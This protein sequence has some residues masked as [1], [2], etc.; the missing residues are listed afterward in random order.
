LILGKIF[1][2]VS[3]GCQ[4]LRLKC[5]KFNFGWDSVPDSAGEAYK[6]VERIRR[7]GREGISR[8]GSHPHVQNPKNILIAELI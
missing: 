6:G 4:I 8:V 1:K 5:N 7:D 3:A 2:F